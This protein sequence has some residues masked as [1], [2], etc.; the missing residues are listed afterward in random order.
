MA[1]LEPFL[2]CWR[3][4]DAVFDRVETR[5]WGAVVS[6]HRYPRIQEANYA[7]VETRQQVGME[8]IE[9]D[10]LPAM[11]RSGSHRA[12]VVIFHPDE[13]TGLVVQAS[14]RGERIAWDLVMEHAGFAEDADPRVEEVLALDEAFWRA[15]RA[16]ARLFDI[17]DEEVLEQLGAVER[18]LL[19]RVGRRWFRVLEGGAPVALGALEVL[20]GVGYI[21]HV[22][23]FP[24]ARRRGHAGALTARLVSEAAAAGADR[25]YLL[26]EPGGVA[27]EMYGR[28][29]FRPVTQI[30]SW[31][32]EIRG[33]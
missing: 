20:R 14:T 16:S 27:A 28:R 30:A 32:S 17:S 22:V 6:D 33:A 10:L 11:G 2:R 25:T 29:G 7:R 15:H 26:A 31:I 23:T 18:D 1:D 12:H 21:D 4:H 5:W 9:A 24:S 8:E 13:Q 3:E 19:A